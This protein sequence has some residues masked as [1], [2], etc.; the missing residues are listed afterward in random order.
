[1]TFKERIEY[2]FRFV[3][4]E[5]NQH[6]VTNQSPSDNNNDE[7]FEQNQNPNDETL[8]QGT[9]NN[10]NP[11]A[12]HMISENNGNFCEN[13]HEQQNQYVTPPSNQNKNAK[14]HESLETTVIIYK[15]SIENSEIDE[16]RYYS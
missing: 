6:D 13:L 1:M 4:E 2:L 11:N 14:Y 9:N 5:K 12:Q 15:D 8:D 7:C 3:I 10:Y 16:E